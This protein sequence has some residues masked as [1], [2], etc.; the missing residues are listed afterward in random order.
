MLVGNKKDLRHLRQVQTEEAKEFCKQH[1]V[2]IEY[3]NKLAL[4]NSIFALSVY[5]YVNT[6]LHASSIAH[7]RAYVG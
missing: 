7:S 4:F 3:I 6:Q 1:Q 5:L 2:K